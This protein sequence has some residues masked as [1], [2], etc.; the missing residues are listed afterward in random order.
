MHTKKQMLGH[1]MMATS[2][3]GLYEYIHQLPNTQIE[4]GEKNMLK[5]L[6]M[7]HKDK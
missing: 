4:S 5:M 6:L 1:K 7:V 2:H 3:S